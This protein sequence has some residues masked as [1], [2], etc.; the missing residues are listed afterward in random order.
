MSMKRKLPPMEYR[1]TGPLVGPAVTGY[2]V[3]SWC[4]TPDGTGPATAVAL[5]METRLPVLDAQCDIVLRLKSPRAV[6]EMVQ[7]L[8]RHKRDVWPESR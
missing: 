2:T 6:D 5:V 3:A 7:A 1:P 8:L 4:P